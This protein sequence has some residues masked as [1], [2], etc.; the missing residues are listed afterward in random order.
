MRLLLALFPPLTSALIY[1]LYWCVAVSC[2]GTNAPGHKPESPLTALLY[3]G[4]KNEALT[5]NTSI[6]NQMHTHTKKNRNENYGKTTHE[7]GEIN[8]E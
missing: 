2:R 1:L 4:I 7:G 5:Y 6:G 3:T 8:R